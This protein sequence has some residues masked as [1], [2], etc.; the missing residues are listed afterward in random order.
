MARS[1][2][3]SF[4]CGG[5]GGQ[6]WL[7]SSGKQRVENL[8]LTEALETGASVVATACPFCKV[9]LETAS[10]TTGQQN[11]VQVKDISELVNAGMER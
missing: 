11:Q 2:E 4:C 3:R 6:M 5:G 10:V 7:E 1:R 8:R 9:M